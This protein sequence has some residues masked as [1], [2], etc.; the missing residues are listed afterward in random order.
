MGWLPTGNKRLHGRV[1]GGTE[2]QPRLELSCINN[3]TM[4]ARVALQRDGGENQ[5][6]LVRISQSQLTGVYLNSKIIK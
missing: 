1:S 5:S 4:N 2:N 3:T 6:F